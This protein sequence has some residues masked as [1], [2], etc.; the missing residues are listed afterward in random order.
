MKTTLPNLSPEPVGRLMDRPEAPAPLGPPVIK[1]RGIGLRYR[2]RKQRV[3]S[4]QQYLFNLIRGQASF[5]DFWPLTD[6]D[7]TVHRGE[8]HGLIG[9]NGQGK[10][11]LLRVLAGIYRPDRGTL[12]ATGKISPLLT[13]GAGFNSELTGRENIYLNGIFL[14]LDRR[15]I[16][17]N[18]E[19]IIEFAD[20]G[21]FIN[22]SIKTYSSGMSARLGFAIALHVEPDI[23]LL[24][25][26]MGVGDEAFKAKCRRAMLDLVDR[27]GAVVLVSHSLG[28][29][30]ELCTTVSWLDRGRVRLTGKPE[31][32]TTA[33]RNS[34]TG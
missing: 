24:D 7:L 25:E 19:A 14:G 16:E 27:A 18:L 12:E 31:E 29:V 10:S 33:Y 11:T 15:R 17:K 21:D 9:S 8:I 23:L 30:K 22:Q 1:A 34:I 28:L 26:V 6:V 3:K 32:V 2:I 5:E 4:F 20:I 13:L